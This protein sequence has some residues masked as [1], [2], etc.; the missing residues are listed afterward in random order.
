[1]SYMKTKSSVALNGVVI[2][3][4]Q[5]SETSVEFEGATIDVETGAGT[6]TLPSGTLDSAEATFTYYPEKMDD[7]KNIWPDMYNAP[8]GSQTSGS[9]VWSSNTCLEATGT[10]VNIH[11]ECI[12]TDDNDFHLFS[13]HVQINFSATWNNQEVLSVEVTVLAQPDE[14]G[15]VGRAGT[16]DLTQASEWDAATGATVPVTSS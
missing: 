9:I 2:P 15:N 11:P 10:P 1:M 3:A 6:F 7:L 12:N 5:L 13:G 14:N 8:S 16:G 4:S